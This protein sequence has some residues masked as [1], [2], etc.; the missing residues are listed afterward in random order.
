MTAT[1]RAELVKLRRRRVLVGAGAFALLFALAAASA[2]I[3]SAPAAG[4]PGE[5][6]PT[7]SSLAEAGGGTAAFAVAVSFLGL[8]VLVLVVA[9]V[10]GELSHGT[11]RTLLM[12]QPH[13][14][15]LLAGTTVALL[16]A[17][18]GLLLVTEVLTWGA[19]L[20]LAPTQGIPTS[21]WLT[22]AALEAALADLG[23]ALAVVAGWTALGVALATLIRSTPLALGVGIAWAGPFEHLL[24]DGWEPATR[25]F[26]GLVLEALG[27]GGTGDVSLARALTL[28]ACYAGVAAA[29]A[30]VSF[31]RRDVTA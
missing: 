2:V 6:R 27:A 18:A 11:M 17:A 5:R 1:I 25:W 28:G 23:T 4:G 16:G 21:E 20:A 15:R 3:L 26:P 24:A 7:L 9:R 10:T 8:L 13:R 22:A 12:R 29:A 30:A 14:L 19:S 31:S